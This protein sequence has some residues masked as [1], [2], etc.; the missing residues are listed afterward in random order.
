MLGYRGQGMESEDD[1]MKVVMAAQLTWDSLGK[2]K[3]E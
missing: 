3:N 2:M 1:G